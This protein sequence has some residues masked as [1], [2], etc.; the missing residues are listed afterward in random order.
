MTNSIEVKPNES[1]HRTVRTYAHLRKAAG[2][3]QAEL[4]RDTMVN[5]NSYEVPPKKG[6]RR[7][8]DHPE[9]VI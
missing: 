4:D 5:E 3:L 8:S 2:I 9:V 6:D 7:R 1:W